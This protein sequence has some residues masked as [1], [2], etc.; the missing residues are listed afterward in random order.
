MKPTKY[1]MDK[2]MR[3]LGRAGKPMSQRNIAKA[4]CMDI[5]RVN[6]AVAYLADH[7][8]LE[9]WKVPGSPYEYSVRKP[10]TPM[11]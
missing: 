7:S 2:I 4:L 9:M 5:N 10:R 11:L 8:R 3:F 1:E 6:H